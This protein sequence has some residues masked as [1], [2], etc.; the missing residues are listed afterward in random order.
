MPYIFVPSILSAHN[1]LQHNCA[2]ILSTILFPS[3]SFFSCPYQSLACESH[4]GSIGSSTVL[5]GIAGIFFGN[6][7][8]YLLNPVNVHAYHELSRFLGSPT[9]ISSYC[10][11]FEYSSKKKLPL[12]INACILFWKN[13]S[14]KNIELIS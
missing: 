5:I 10:F 9:R 8:D 7:P 1:I 2:A 6:W 4:F 14:K 11:F 13:I 3:L 12:K